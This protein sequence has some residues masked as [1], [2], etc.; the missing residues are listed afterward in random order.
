MKIEVSNS[1]PYPIYEQISR[2][3]RNFI[4]SGELSSGDSL[5]SI[6][7]LANDLQVSVITTK[8]AYD[9]LEKEGYLDS[10]TGR[11]TFV[12]EKNKELVRE[13]QMKIIEDR[14][15]EAV[16]DAKLFGVSLKELSQMLN[17]FYK[18]K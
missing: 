12:A 1:S 3:I 7:S 15:H 6:R 18:S 11:G 8:K 5:P 2:Q 9:L 4:I 10:V 13:I 14:I 17:M 16:S